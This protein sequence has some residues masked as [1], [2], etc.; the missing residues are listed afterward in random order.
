MSTSPEAPPQILFAGLSAEELIAAE[1][2]HRADPEPSILGKRPSQTREGDSDDEEYRSPSPEDRDNS[3]DSNPSD[4]ANVSTLRTEQAV[5]RLRK[6]LKLSNND[7][8][9]I[10]Q[11][12][13]VR[14]STFHQHWPV[15]DEAVAGGLDRYPSDDFVWQRYH[16][17][18]RT[19]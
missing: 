1:Q 9:L 10:G 6:R 14:I 4:H 19:R 8:A 17:R 7:T 2:G 3:G 13:Q 16:D 11:F 18:E 15:A 5:R 12:A